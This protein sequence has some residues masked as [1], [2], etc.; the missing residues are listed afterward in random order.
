MRI[1]L[2][3]AVSVVC[4]GALAQDTLTVDRLV[5]FMRSAIQVKQRD[6]EVA[7]YVSRM[8]LSQKL[9]DRTIEELQSEGLGPRTVAAL[10][11]LGGASASLPEPEVK[12]VEPPAPKPVAHPPSIAEQKKIV[13]EAREYA[14]NYSKGLPNFICAQST[15]RFDNNRMY[16]NVLAKLTYYQQ[17]EKYDTIMVNDKLTNKAYD[18][19]GGSISTGEF[20]SMLM[21]IFDPQTD[22]VFSWSAWQE[23]RGHKAY[24]FKF[25]VDREHSRWQIED[26]QAAVRITPAY[27]GFVW[28]DVK[29]R[30]VLAFTMQAIDMP[31]SFPISAANSRLDYDIVEI[32]GVPF[33]LPSRAV[34]HLVS[35]R[36]D[37]K[38]EITFHN[39][40]KYSAD[41]T[42]K[43]DEP[44]SETPPK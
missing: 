30:S 18:T 28:V 37:Q 17:R 16:D 34:M 5:Q 12:K 29:D 22:A 13:D 40:Q 21:G 24:V 31:A 44:V 8:K 15:K 6:A 33:M 10:R 9:D 43:F 11:K 2:A 4:L 14:M 38:N 32:S 23:I 36:D 39:Y 41:A 42:L 19:L 26:K 35:A 27:K 1:R 20:G 25:V 7:A 3:I